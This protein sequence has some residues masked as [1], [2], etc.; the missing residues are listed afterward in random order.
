MKTSIIDVPDLLSVLT[1]D[2]VE[3]KI[4]E[5]PGVASATV[6]YAAKSATVRYDETLLEIADIK[7]LVHQRGQQSAGESKPKDDNASKS[8]HQSDDKPEHKHAEAPTPTPDAATGPTSPPQP[9]A[10]K[11]AMPTPGAPPADAQRTKPTPGA[12]PVAAAPGA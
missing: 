1:V 8:D 10:P 4:G 7:V 3:K 5:V 11:A 2:D 12:P 9:A 6:N